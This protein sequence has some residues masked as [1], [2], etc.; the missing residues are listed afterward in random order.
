[1]SQ[2]LKWMVA[3]AVAV[4]MTSVAV[5]ND[6]VADTKATAPQKSI[7][8]K[9]KSVFHK[10]D[11]N[12]DGKVTT[13]EHK[14]RLKKWFKEMDVNKDA[15]LTPEEFEGQ[16]FVNIDINKDG[17]VTMEEYLVFFAGIKSAALADQQTGS[18]ELDADSNNVITPVEVIAYRKS[19]FNAIDTKGEGKV[20]P[21]KMKAHIDKQF[22]NLDADKDGFVTVE[23]L[24]AIIA[25]PA[26]ADDQPAE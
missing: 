16:R 24:T 9:I 6:K 4:A 25:L 13:H 11:V 3:G 7:L 21:D 17:I 18:N 22:K 14:A 15:K 20:K 19:V 2:M 23:E 12:N 10:T 5:A 8:Q 1:M 26:A